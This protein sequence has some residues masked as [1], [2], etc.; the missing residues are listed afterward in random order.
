[1]N[2]KI[3]SSWMGAIALAVAL[4]SSIES[5]ALNI[6]KN[7][8]KGNGSIVLAVKNSSNT[9]MDK[10]T[11]ATSLNTGDEVL[12]Y[13]SPAEDETLQTL[14]INGTDYS[15]SPVFVTVSGD[16]NI[17]ASFEK[18]TLLYKES[19]PNTTGKPQGLTGLYFTH[20]EC[21]TPRSVAGCIGTASMGNISS[22]GAV[23]YQN[24]GLIIYFKP[25]AI[26]G[27]NLQLKFRHYLTG[28]NNATTYA[29]MSKFR[30]SLNG[31]ETTVDFTTATTAG[32]AMTD[33][34]TNIPSPYAEGKLYQFNPS[35]FNEITNTTYPDA[36][37]APYM[38]IPLEGI[39]SLSK[40]LIDLKSGQVQNRGRIDDVIIVGDGTPIYSYDT[41]TSVNQENIRILSCST[42]EGGIELNGVTA[43]QAI[44]VYSASGSKVISVMASGET[45][46][47]PTTSLNNGIYIVSIT[48]SEYRTSSNFKVCVK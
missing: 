22:A 10:V 13:A 42:N 27:N 31:T 35:D 18:R 12:V 6:T 46:L 28:V 3:Y 29:D 37:R 33:G 14:T 25:N 48:D 19:F 23:Y 24:S 44:N 11:E 16:L 4:S 2:T 32:D 45:Q 17:S 5:Y 39:S 7:V 8:T 38:V 41:S 36:N 9:N 34:G 1:M 26:V 40:I 21:T 43:G 47:I 30:I 20:T 15:V